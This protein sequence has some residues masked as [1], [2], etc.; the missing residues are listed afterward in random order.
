[1]MKL[2]SFFLLFLFIKDPIPQIFLPQLFIMK[3]VHSVDYLKQ[4]SSELLYAVCIYRQ[5]LERH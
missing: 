4:Q 3:N 2:F 1:M 5:N